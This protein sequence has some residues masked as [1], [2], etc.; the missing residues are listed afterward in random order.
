MVFVQIG[1]NQGHDDLMQIARENRTRLSKLILV[2][3]L[4][5]HHAA[6]RHGYSGYPVT[7]EHLAIV[8]DP[9]LQQVSFF[10]H[11]ED[12]PGYEVSSLSREHILKHVSCNPRLT[13][14]GIVE[15]KVPAATLNQLLVRHGVSKIELLVIDAEG[16]DDRIIRSID[17]GQFRIENIVYENLHIPRQALAD[18]LKSKGY[19]IVPEWGKN[20]WSSW[21]ILNAEP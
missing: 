6:L 7:V 8:D 17:F 15:E 4:S 13:E 18:F 19:S 14:E 5:V 9:A 16:F 3:P 21:A 11:V 10:Y 1:A 20:G 2:E 12:G